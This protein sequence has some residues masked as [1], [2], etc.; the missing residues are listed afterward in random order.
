[1]SESQCRYGPKLSTCRPIVPFGIL[2]SSLHLAVRLSG[3]MRIRSKL[4]V[5]KNTL[6]VRQV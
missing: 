3:H 5:P 4:I 1:M 6:E 2:G